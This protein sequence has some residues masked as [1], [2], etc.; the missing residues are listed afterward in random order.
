MISSFDELAAH[1]S[2]LLDACRASGLSVATA[3]SCT[4]GLIAAALTEVAGSSDVFDRGFVTYS[5]AAKT[6]LLGVSAE[7]ITAHGAVSEVVARAMAEGALAR[8]DADLSVAVTGIAGPSGGSPAK[9]I[10]T[11]HLVAAHRGGH[12]IHRLLETGDIGRAAVR[13]QSAAEALRL[14]TSALPD[15][16]LP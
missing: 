16:R 13:L 7:L 10:G 9:P 6:A 4:G 11:V 5:D 15:Q 8:S 2:D 14:L 1:A 3:E 12:V